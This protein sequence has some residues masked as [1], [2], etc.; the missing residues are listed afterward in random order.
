MQHCQGFG[1]RLEPP[2]QV[3]K[4]YRQCCSRPDKSCR[5]YVG[6]MDMMSKTVN[7]TV[8][9]RGCFTLFVRVRDEITRSAGVSS[10]QLGG[11]RQSSVCSGAPSPQNGRLVDS[12]VNTRRERSNTH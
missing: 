12:R 9:A 10:G 1:F 8:S 7:N 3:R 2:I 6:A 11:R 5:T 4:A